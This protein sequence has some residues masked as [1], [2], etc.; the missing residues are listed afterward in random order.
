MLYIVNL[1][2]VTDVSGDYSAFISRIKQSRNRCG[3][4]GLI[5]A[6]DEGTVLL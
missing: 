4:L 3:L 1:W 5:D 2:I 6:E